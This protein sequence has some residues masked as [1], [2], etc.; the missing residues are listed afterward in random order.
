ME[1]EQTWIRAIQRRN[2]REAA[3]QKVYAVRR[4]QSAQDMVPLRQVL[5]EVLDRLA[6]HEDI[7]GGHLG[8]NNV[9][10]IIRL[11][12]GEGYGLTAE[13]GDTGSRV[14]LRLPMMKGDSHAKG[15]DR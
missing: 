5:P 8:L 11:Y 6:R 9:D 10:R 4:G 3:E 1:R 2:S 7:P 15:T 14:T 13:S 12:Y